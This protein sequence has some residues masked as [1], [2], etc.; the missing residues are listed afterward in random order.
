MEPETTLNHPTSP[1]IAD[2][3]PKAERAASVEEVAPHKGMVSMQKDKPKPSA[4]TKSVSKSDIRR[5]VAVWNFEKSYRQQDRTTID[6]G[7]QLLLPPQQGNEPTPRRGRV[8]AVYSALQTCIERILAKCGCHTFIYG[9][10]YMIGLTKIKEATQQ[11]IP[12]WLDIPYITIKN[13]RP[14]W[15]HLQASIKSEQEALHKAHVE[16]TQRLQDAAQAAE[17]PQH[18]EL[19]PPEHAV[20]SQQEEV[21]PQ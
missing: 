13:G 9:P 1:A 20:V 11:K 10:K 12:K 21:E 17:G 4:G 18:H 5:V 8:A 6:L 2:D 14:T 7:E 15:E 19:D 3:M 16:S